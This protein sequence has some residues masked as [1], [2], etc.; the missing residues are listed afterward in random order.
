MTLWS[1]G[2]SHF[3]GFQLVYNS[4]SLVGLPWVFSFCQVL[5]AK[6]HL[7]AKPSLGLWRPCCKGRW[8][9]ERL[10]LGCCTLY[11]AH[12][13]ARQLSAPSFFSPLTL[14]KAGPRWK[15]WKHV[16]C[17]L[18]GIEKILSRRKRRT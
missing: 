6:A 1:L 8:S 2:F 5:S 9:E 14:Q 4:C 3:L 15:S 7:T 13:S 17:A 11:T 18:K 10:P 16:S 12:N